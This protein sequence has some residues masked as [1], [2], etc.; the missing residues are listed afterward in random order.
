MPG[1]ERAGDAA[2]CGDVNTGSTT[3]FA[4]GQGIA[5]VGVDSAGGTIGG[6][7]SSTVFVEGSNV[8]LPG[9]SIA[10]HGIEPHAAPVTANPSEDVFAGS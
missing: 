7:G 5:R 3:V 8:S 4:N 9:D 1:V 2:T 6:P 10:G